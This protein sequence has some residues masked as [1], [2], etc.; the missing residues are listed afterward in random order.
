MDEE[1]EVQEFA[2]LC[3]AI[4]GSGLNIPEE[5]TNLRD[6]VIAVKSNPP[7]GGGRDD[8][9][10]PFDLPTDEENAANPMIMSFDSP[11]RR[12]PGRLSDAVRAMKAAVHRNG[13]GGTGRGGRGT[14][15]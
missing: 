8:D 9:D 4:R 6:L 12:R 2:A 1:P 13:Y 10:N 5:V 11:V 7:R 3:D 14:G 15:A